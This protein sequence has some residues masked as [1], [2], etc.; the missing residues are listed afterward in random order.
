MFLLIINE[1][2]GQAKYQNFGTDPEQDLHYLH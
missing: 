1:C 2:R